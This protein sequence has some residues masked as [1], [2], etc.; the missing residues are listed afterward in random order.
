ML[1]WRNLQSTSTINEMTQ[2][3]CAAPS[4]SSSKSMSYSS[5]SSASLITQ[6]LGEKASRAIAETKVFLIGAGGIGCEVLKNLV[7]AGFLH[8]DVI[9]LDTID[10]TNL[11]RQF[12]FRKEHVDK[13]KAEVA[14]E[15]VRR[16]FFKRGAGAE[17]KLKITPHCGDVKSLSAEFFEQF[18]VVIN[19]LDNINARHHVNR[20]CV[21]LSKPL[22]EA[23]TTGYE[24]QTTVH[25]P[26]VTEC[27]ECLARPKPV[28][29]PVCT[30]RKTPDKPIH[31][32]TWAKSLFDALYGPEDAGNVLADFR[33]ELSVVVGS[34]AASSSKINS[35]PVVDVSGA[36]GGGSSNV[37]AGGTSTSKDS[38]CTKS[39]SST[40]L[41][42]ALDLCD[43]LF[44]DDIQGLYD[45][46][47]IEK[48]WDAARP[49]PRRL[50]RS[51]DL[52]REFDK[53]L[54]SQE[55]R[56]KGL[57]DVSDGPVGERKDTDHEEETQTT[58]CFDEIEAK[59]ERSK[60]H[61]HSEGD[62]AWMTQVMERAGQVDSWTEDTQV[63]WTA[64]KSVYKLA[65]AIQRI[66]QRQM[67]AFEKSGAPLEVVFRKEDDA[68]VD[69]VSAVSNLRSLNYSIP[70]QTK[71]K[72]TSMAG[73]IVP[74]IATTNSIVAGL[75]VQNLV[76]LVLATKVNGSC[77]SAGSSG[78][79]GS[80]ATRGSSTK[81]SCT[82]ATTTTANQR[83]LEACRDCFCMYPSTLASR[84]KGDMIVKSGRAQPPK[85]DCLVCAG[86]TQ[87]TLYVSKKKHEEASL[88]DFLVDTVLRGHFHCHEPA[89]N[90]SQPALLDIYDPEFPVASEEAA[91]EGFF[92]DRSL[93]ACGAK[94]GSILSIC[95]AS[96]VSVQFDA[97]LKVIDKWNEENFPDFFAVNEKREDVELVELSPEDV[98]EEAADLEDEEAVNVEVADLSPAKKKMRKE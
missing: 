58:T 35:N 47:E 69:F 31:C 67:D 7:L 40:T 10:V 29:Y 48:T 65:S 19:A 61:Q 1:T 59:Q 74:A 88:K 79:G 98:D 92:P 21:G 20:L 13:S 22:L 9:D 23:G 53:G 3:P 49:R 76:H 94:H 4:T 14:V 52:L 72:V 73:N 83:I 2:L 96:Q 97:L 34:G 70:P 15:R 41:S 60:P 18:D 75:Q 30:I 17:E 77:A 27:Y 81:D 16:F 6:I 42:G 32:I 12:L 24:G 36:V 86:N 62:L 57:V 95:D 45:S 5:A 93:A 46:G 64:G 56:K 28:K 50:R 78:T 43:R 85:K 11:N 25:V 90:V 55:A 33:A 51:I 39:T 66:R 54:Y 26:G 71:W 38:S 68:A 91:A 37:A 8:I 63:V 82:K 87:V 80:A 44:R 84:K 89:V